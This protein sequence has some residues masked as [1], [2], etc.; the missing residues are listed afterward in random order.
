MVV[1][2]GKTFMPLFSE[3]LRANRPTTSFT[4]T[5]NMASSVRVVNRLLLNATVLFEGLAP[6]VKI[7]DYV[8]QGKY[9]VTITSDQNLAVASCLKL[10]NES[11]KC[12]IIFSLNLTI[13]NPK[14]IKAG[15]LV[16]GLFWVFLA[17]DDKLTQFLLFNSGKQASLNFTSTNITDVDSITMGLPST[18]LVSS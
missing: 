14:L 1:L 6:D 11:I 8:I 5:S 15:S 18:G 7:S 13:K 4:V 16:D 17:Q 3:D 10:F 12:R 9:S 2:A